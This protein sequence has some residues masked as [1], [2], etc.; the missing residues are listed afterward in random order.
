MELVEDDNNG[1]RGITGRYADFGILRPTEGIQFITTEEPNHQVTDDEG[2]RDK[3]VRRST[4][5]P[6]NS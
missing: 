2:V 4:C 5:I 1:S 6:G 3:W